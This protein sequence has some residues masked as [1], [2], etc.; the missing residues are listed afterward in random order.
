MRAIIIEDEVRSQTVLESLLNITC[1]DVQVVGTADSITSSIKLIQ[2]AN[3][4]LIFLDVQLKDG[5]GFQV[6]EELSDIDAAVIFTTAYDQYAIKA[7]RFSAIDYLLKPIEIEELKN[8][9]EKTR[10]SR[11]LDYAK[12]QLAGF[13]HNLN[14]STNDPPLLSVS[15]SDSVEFVK[16]KEIIRCEASGAYC[17][18]FVKDSKMI[19]ISKVIKELEQLLQEY[20]FF[21]AH[22]THLINLSEI[23]QYKRYDNTIMM[24]DNST[25]PL[26]R[27]RKDGF[28]KMI[29]KLKI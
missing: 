12:K 27:S 24:S 15:T 1:P 10:E 28:F 16:I 26:A 29:N 18:I 25:I 3:P 21:R 23:R 2:E 13:I 9:V 20:N 7:F 14:L 19:M 22:Q 11:H 5:L 17:K 4:D 8:A 6:L